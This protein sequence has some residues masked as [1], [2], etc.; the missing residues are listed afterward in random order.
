MVI[1]TMAIQMLVMVASPKGFGSPL[2]QCPRAEEWSSRKGLMEIQEQGNE[3]FWSCDLHVVVTK[4]IGKKCI[5]KA[6]VAKSPQQGE[7]V[8]HE[9]LPRSGQPYRFDVHRL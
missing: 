4:K 5:W 7:G 6:F 9:R 1:I 8:Q 3:Y 2:T